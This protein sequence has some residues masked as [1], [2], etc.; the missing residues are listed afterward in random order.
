M[1]MQLVT[2]AFKL[3]AGFTHTALQL[4]SNGTWLN[5]AMHGR[6][7]VNEANEEHQGGWGR[8]IP[9]EEVVI[10]LWYWHVGGPNYELCDANWAKSQAKTAK[11]AVGFP[12][13]VCTVDRILKWGFT[14]SEASYADRKNLKRTRGAAKNRALYHLHRNIE[15]DIELVME[16][17]DNDEDY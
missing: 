16:L 12:Y 1:L 15:S 8:F 2:G 14:M 4:Q 11:S 13:V 7:W 17:N 6:D 5:D 10:G 9:G 3:E